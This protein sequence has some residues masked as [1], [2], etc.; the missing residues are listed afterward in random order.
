[1]YGKKLLN[2]N[3]K[4]IYSS[5]HTGNSKVLKYLRGSY[6]KNA[7]IRT[8]LLKNKRSLISNSHRSK[9]VLIK[10]RKHKRF[11]RFARRVCRSILRIVKV[12]DPNQRRSLHLADRA[13]RFFRNLRNRFRRARYRPKSFYFRVQ[14]NQKLSRNTF[15]NRMVRGCVRNRRPM[16][17]FI[18][19]KF[20]AF[21]FF[22]KKTLVKFQGLYFI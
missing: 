9:K 22:N 13:D 16:D 21:Y 7:L 19:H 10:S 1:M 4:Q 3:P 17:R 20:R 5:I 18:N 15:T 8:L 2:P 14:V 6:N 11:T 12:W